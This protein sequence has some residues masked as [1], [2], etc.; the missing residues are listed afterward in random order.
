MQR[1]NWSNLSVL[2]TGGSGFVGANLARALLLLNA[3][4]IVLERDRVAPCALDLLGVRTN[5]TVI[6]GS[7]EDLAL[8]ERILNEYQPSMVFH[9]AAQALVGAANRSPLATFD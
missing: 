4:V 6:T 2:I 7:V 8:C 9:L 3:N 5:L 1:R